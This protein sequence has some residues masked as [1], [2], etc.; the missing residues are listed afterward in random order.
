MTIVAT[1][2]WQ[3]ALG[4]RPLLHQPYKKLKY[5]E[6]YGLRLQQKKDDNKQEHKNKA[7]CYSISSCGV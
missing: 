6:N 5:L 3:P 7:M 1:K 4:F 2:R